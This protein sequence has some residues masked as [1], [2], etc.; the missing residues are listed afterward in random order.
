M[1]AIRS[2][3]LAPLAASVA[4][5]LLLAACSSDAAT[6]APATEPSTSVAGS[7]TTS[8][9]ATSTTAAPA[10]STTAAPTTAAPTT[11]APTT[12]APAP[13]CGE[14]NV[15]SAGAS[16]V[17]TITG[18]WNGDGVQDQATSWVEPATMEWFVMIEVAG[19]SSTTIA[20]PDP[21]V[22]FVQV[23]DKVDVDFSL[24]VDPG[25]NR[26]EFVAI[27]GSNS[28]GLNLG[29]FGVNSVG[30]GFPFDN[31][32]GAYYVIP[33]H[34]SAGIMSGLKCDGG[35]GSQFMV[36]LEASTTDGDIWSTRDIK[37]E[38]TGPQSLGDGVVIEGAYLTG[39]P[40]LYD[41]NVAY[42]FDTMLI[43]GAID[44]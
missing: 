1:I 39:E 36:R 14:G 27:V 24:G 44:Y 3:R 7:T 18:D 43:D 13:A 42:C 33:I 17:A 41:Y 26:D 37:I 10:A 23:V 16:S 34:S 30:C 32:A 6:T 4:G 9:A 12:A 22:G 2:R 31:G 19:G 20:M 35:A 40:E 38:R 25:V 15:P 29:V 28:S 5:L 11:A 21:G 8:V